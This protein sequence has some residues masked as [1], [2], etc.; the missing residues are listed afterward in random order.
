[1]RSFGKSKFA[2]LYMAEHIKK[3][4]V[5]TVCTSNP[6]LIV[7]N[8]KEAGLIVNYQRIEFSKPKQE[9]GIYIFKLK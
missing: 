7:K 8:L 4:G 2:T 1:M 5:I 3:R 6:N 9:L